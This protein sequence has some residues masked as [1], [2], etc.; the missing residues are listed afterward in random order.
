VDIRARPHVYGAFF[1]FL[2]FVLTLA[3]GLCCAFTYILPCVGAG[4]R[5]N[6]LAISTGPKSVGSTEDGDRIQSLKG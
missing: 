3:D 6:R 5:G 1:V 4:V 2:M